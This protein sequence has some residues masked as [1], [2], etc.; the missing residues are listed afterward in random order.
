MPRVLLAALVFVA[1][2]PGGSPAASP[3]PAPTVT[4]TAAVVLR[5]PAAAILPAAGSLPLTGASDHLTAAEYAASAPD[6]VVALGQVESWGWAAAARR[7]WSAGGAAVDDVVLETDRPEGA[8]RAFEAWA[9]AASSAPF[10]GGACPAAVT[11]LDDCRQGVAGGR[12]VVV[13]RLDAEVFR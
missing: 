8:Q 12:T 2:S 10:A 13:G 1:C 9:G 3:R 5:A 7:T 11:G 4:P 6:E